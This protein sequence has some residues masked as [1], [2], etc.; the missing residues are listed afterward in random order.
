MCSCNFDK[1]SVTRLQQWCPCKGCTESPL[2]SPPPPSLEPEVAA[3]RREAWEN[4]HPPIQ[5]VFKQLFSPAEKKLF[6]PGL[7]V[8]LVRKCCRQTPCGAMLI[9][10]STHRL[11]GLCT[12]AQPSWGFNPDML[13][14]PSAPFS[15]LTCNYLTSGYSSPTFNLLSTCW[16][17]RWEKLLSFT[18]LIETFYFNRAKIWTHGNT[19]SH[20]GS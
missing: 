8:W 6:R 2:V 4:T 15:N 19:L 17:L 13:L 18:F 14:P 11:A 1:Y 3:W 12:V 20:Q 16:F 10:I 5:S 7:T 9:V